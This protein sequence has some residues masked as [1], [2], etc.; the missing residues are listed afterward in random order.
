MQTIN[1]IIPIMYSGADPENSERR[2]R[3]NCG[4]SASLPL[5]PPLKKF[6]FVEMLLTAF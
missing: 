1:E 5:P 2:D 6:T 3:R 4:E